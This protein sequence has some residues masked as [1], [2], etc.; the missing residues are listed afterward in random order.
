MKRTIPK[1][2]E[3]AYVAE[4]ADA[5]PDKAKKIAA[6]LGIEWRRAYRWLHRAGLRFDRER[7]P[8]DVKAFDGEMTE[9]KAYWLG[10]LMADGHIEEDEA[11]EPSVSLSQSTTAHGPD[12]EATLLA[13]AKFLGSGYAVP[14]RVDRY[15]NES[16]GTQIR[17]LELAESLARHGVLPRKTNRES[18]SPGLASNRNF[19]RGYVDGDGSPGLNRNTPKIEVVGSIRILEQ[20]LSFAGFPEVAIRSHHGT[21]QIML[22]GRRAVMAG[23]LMYEPSSVAMAGKKATVLSWKSLKTTRPRQPKP[24]GSQGA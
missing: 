12:G 5:G 23:L 3:D 1:E 13:F 2:V 20:F 18:A 19:W 7:L 24:P 22:Y 11:K 6:S 10:F 16:I 21:G 8:L 15:G 17:S 9:E 4:V 14:K